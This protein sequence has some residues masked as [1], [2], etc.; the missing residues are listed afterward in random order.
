MEIPVNGFK[1][2]IATTDVA[3]GTWLSASSPSTAE[4][5]GC[6]GYD[7]LVVDM[8]HSPIEFPQVVE[9]LRAIAGTPASPVTRVPWNDMVMVKRAL[10]AG[11][12]TLMLPLIQNADEA[13]RAVA[14]TRYPP[15]GVRGVAGMQRASRF[16]MVND[17]AR[18]A[19]DEL[20]VIVQIETADALAQLPR[21]VEVRGVDSVF[22]GP[23]DLAASMGHLGDIMHKD[24][25]KSLEQAAQACRRLGVPCGCLGANPEMTRRFRDYGYSWMAMGSDISMM[26]SRAR[27]WLAEVVPSSAPAANPAGAY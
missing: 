20:C 8:E 24:V 14:Y 26:G 22:V 12:Q 11:A 1:R 9:M 19:A 10:D 21:I 16:G 25:Q 15:D 5:L 6:A 17:Y 23:S 7:F 2:K 18:R 13:R 4:A 3:Y 27:E